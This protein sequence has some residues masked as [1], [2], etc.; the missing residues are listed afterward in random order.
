MQQGVFPCVTSMKYLLF[1][2]LRTKTK[3]NKTVCTVR[4]RT[5]QWTR[6]EVTFKSPGLNTFLKRLHLHR[7]HKIVESHSIQCAVCKFTQ[8]GEWIYIQLKLEWVVVF[9][10]K[11]ITFKLKVNCN[12]WHRLL[13]KKLKLLKHCKQLSKVQVL[14]I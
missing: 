9:L 4:E 5:T 11:N 10:C 2:L 3:K 12:Q 13:N 8:I 1:T 14:Q 7:A 6:M